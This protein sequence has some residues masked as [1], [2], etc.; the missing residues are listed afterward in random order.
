VLNKPGPLDAAETALMQRHV[1]IGLRI[2][3][4]IEVLH[5]VLPLVEFHQERWDGRREGVSFPGYTGLAGESIP[6]GARIL[7]VVDAFD[8]MTNDRPYRSARSV[9]AA[10]AELEAESA[11]QFD[12]RVVEAMT[13]LVRAEGPNARSRRG[14]LSDVAIPVV[15]PPETGAGGRRPAAGA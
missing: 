5:D 14:R 7:A 1:D 9:E 15:I 6:I 12:P 10:L 13:N 3:G 11:R 8:A 2:L 4:A